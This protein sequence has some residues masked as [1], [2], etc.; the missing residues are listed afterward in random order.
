MLLLDFLRNGGEGTDLCKRPVDLA[1][2]GCPMLHGVV[3][4]RVG[5]LIGTREWGWVVRGV[6]K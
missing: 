6:Q 3:V 2:C 1:V 4:K 5:W